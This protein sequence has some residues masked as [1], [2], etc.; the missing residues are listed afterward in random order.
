MM[1][2][3]EEITKS[4]PREEGVRKRSDVTRD[5]EKKSKRENTIKEEKRRRYKQENRREK[6]EKGLLWVIAGVKEGLNE[7]RTFSYVN[8]ESI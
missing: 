2:G 4:S 7:H 3:G 6:K 5:E 8:E 1:R